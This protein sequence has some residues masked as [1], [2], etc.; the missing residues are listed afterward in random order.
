M[1][2]GEDKRPA[3][4]DTY[5]ASKKRTLSQTDRDMEPNQSRHLDES[6]PC[7][8]ETGLESVISSPDPPHGIHPAMWAMLRSIKANTDKANTLAENIDHRVLILED[9]ADHTGATLAKIT[10]QMNTITETNNVLVSRLIRAEAKIERQR[11]EIVD[12]RARSMRDNII[13]KTSGTEYKE[14]RDEDTASVVQTFLAKEMKVPYTEKIAIPRAHRMGKAMDGKNRMM[15]AKIAFDDDLKRIFANADALKN[16]NF[17]ISKQIPQ[18]VEE[19]RQFGWAVRKKARSEGRFARFDGGRLVFDSEIVTKYDPVALPACSYMTGGPT[20]SRPI[21][22]VSDS[23]TVAGHRFQCWLASADSLQSVRDAYDAMIITKNA[24]N[25]DHIPYAFR[26]HGEEG[27]TE[28]NFESDG[29]H[30]AGL[31]ALKVMKLKGMNDMSVFVTHVSS[32]I[33]ISMK[34]KGDAI[35]HVVNDVYIKWES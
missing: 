27:G 28:E 22:Q 10:A 34:A 6:E 17:Q 9:Q 13:I 4:S 15:I 24:A 21:F 14:R 18:E 32:E 7:L 19:R 11:C 25:A 1:P 2:P 5:I 16:T 12:L 35:K 30:G 8:T 33:P 3:I 26:F 20:K 31:H 23:H 29:D